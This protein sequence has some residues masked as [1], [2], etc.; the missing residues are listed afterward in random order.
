MES[1]DLNEKAA[2]VAARVFRWRQ[3][4]IGSRYIENNYNGTLMLNWMKRHGKTNWT[5]EELDECFLAV[6]DQQLPEDP[7]PDEIPEPEPTPPP[8]P[9]PEEM[10]GPW[11]DLTK[12]QVIKMAGSEM[13][14]A[15]KDPRFNAK[16][17]SLQIT[18]AELARR[19]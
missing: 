5:P 1:N 8:P 16:V 14:F 4:D 6:E 15:G 19:G 13:R 3:T 18:R 12:E 17:D 10:Y 11:K 2:A 7:K 9:S